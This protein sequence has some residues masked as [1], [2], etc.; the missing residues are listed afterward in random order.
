VSTVSPGAV[1]NVFGIRSFRLQWPADLTISWAFEMETLV[2]SW[3]VLVET[4]SVFLLTVFASLQYFGTFFA[5]IV[6]VIGD[7]IGHRNLL[8]M[9]RGSYF[10]LGTVLLALIVSDWIT[11]AWVL[12]VTALMGIAR[13][14]D[15]AT[16]YALIGV[17]MPS[18]VLMR[19]MSVSRTT[20]DSARIVG[21]LS[22]AGLV[23]A[24]GMR[25]AYSGV[26]LMYAVSLCLTLAIPSASR[27]PRS[28]TSGDRHPQSV[29]PWLDL[30][31]VFAY[32]LR[33]PHLSAALWIAFLVNIAAYPLVLG[34][35][36]YVAKEIYQ[37][38][39]TG[40]GYLAAS[41]S[42]GGLIGSLVLARYSAVRPARWM[43]VFSAGWF[44]VLL[45]FAQTRDPA[46]GFFALMLAGC[47]QNFCLVPLATLLIRHSDAAY[48]GRIMGMRMF[49]IYGLPIGLLAAGPLIATFG[50]APVASLYCGLGLLLTWLIAW[51]WREQVWWLK[52]AANRR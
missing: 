46:L 14:A 37:T 44:A 32:V 39:Q 27:S 45:V 36:P 17:T 13:S 38:D 48:R 20:L 40:L 4:N 47:A 50:F 42:S 41:F 6:G 28:T 21:A 19:A 35:L 31:E 24:L 43:I 3:Y 51:Y 34:L 2:L 15:M 30:K 25:W 1:H 16:R 52:A 18:E 29:S 5:P 23:A 22:G 33:T 11:P 12:L 49:A 26:V 10:L 8:C 9:M 7:R